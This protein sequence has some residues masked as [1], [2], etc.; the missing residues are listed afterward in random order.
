MGYGIRGLI[1]AA[2]LAAAGALFAVPAHAQVGYDRVGGDA[3]VAGG[4]EQLG[5]LGRARQRPHDRVLAATG[6][7]NKYAHVLG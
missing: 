6:S 7:D 1:V 2:V 3:G 4:A 5:G